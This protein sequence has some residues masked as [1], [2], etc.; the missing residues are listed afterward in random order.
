MKLKTN[1]AKEFETQLGNPLGQLNNLI[2]QAHSLKVKQN[3]INRF[4]ESPEDVLGN[5][6]ENCI[7]EYLEQINDEEFM[8][9]RL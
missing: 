6:W 4:G 9:D 1:Y 7:E 5:D 2:A 3:F 8:I